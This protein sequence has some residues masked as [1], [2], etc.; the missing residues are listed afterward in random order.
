MTRWPRALICDLDGTLIDSAPDVATAAVHALADHGVV[1]EAAQA[2]AWL[3][4]GPRVFM[5]RAADH[6]RIP[7]DDGALDHRVA[8]FSA[9]YAA[10]PCRLTQPFEQAHD[11]LAALRR[12]RVRVG[13]CT[14]KP[15]HIARLVL[16]QTGLSD[17][18][19]VLVGGGRH[20]LK[21]APDGLLACLARLEAIPQDALYIGDHE[22]D[23]QAARAAGI[24][25]ALA[26][27]GYSQVPVARFRADAEFHHWSEIGT[28]IEALAHD[29]RSA[30]SR[31]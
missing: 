7:L 28:V 25:V 5:R 27:F 2:R 30:A 17:V 26:T 16:E 31:Q 13:V 11:T 4:H 12:E 24:C 1:I 15:E 23:V 14:N 19:D 10:H 29:G 3:G 6:F 8:G 21:P 9:Y 22:A 20:A 18:V